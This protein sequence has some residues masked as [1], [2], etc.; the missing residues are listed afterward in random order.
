[1][2]TGNIFTPTIETQAVAP[3]VPSP[4]EDTTTAQAIQAFTPMIA[5]G[6]KFGIAKHDMNKLQGQ[7]EGIN[8]ELS[9]LDKQFSSIDQAAKTGGNKAALQ[10]R[11]RAALKTAIAQNPSISSSAEQMFNNY[12]ATT[13]SSGKGTSGAFTLSPQEKAAQ[14]VKAKV[15]TYQMTFGWDESKALE[16]VQAE[17][18][19]KIAKAKADELANQSNVAQYHVAPIVD[20]MVNGRAVDANSY[21]LNHLKTQGAFSPN[22]KLVYSRKLDAEGAQLKQKFLRSVTNKDGSYSVSPDYVQNQLKKIDDQTTSLKSI[23]SDSSSVKLLE[24]SNRVA[25]AKMNLTMMQKFPKMMTLHKVLGD[26]ATNSFIQAL[27]SGNTRLVSYIE[28]QNPELREILGGQFNFTEDLTVDGSVKM[29]DKDNDAPMTGMEKTA[30]GSFMNSNAQYAMKILEHAGADK[31]T[32]LGKAHPDS[33]ASTHTPNT[34]AVREGNPKMANSV[35][36]MQY[37]VIQHLDESFRDKYGRWPSGLKITVQKSEPEKLGPGYYLM[38]PRAVQQKRILVSA[39]DGT[40]LEQEDVN[41]VAELYRSIEANPDT[42]PEGLKGK[43][44]SPAQIATI[45][46]NAGMDTKNL[47]KF[48]PL[49]QKLSA[50]NM[51]DNNYTEYPPRAPTPYGD[52]TPR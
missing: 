15:A 45:W 43:G 48:E 41:M 28:A 4:V 21:V 6:V 23:V 3:R 7:F 35:S 8:D 51:N 30:T 44:L 16:A 38:W 36:A 14:Q 26:A 20:S 18:G 50:D 37:G 42:I 52:V 10:V 27:S 32:A 46:I 49:I 24:E 2:A 34:K 39:A 31:L 47:S 40:S 12:F 5:E 11:A 22:D 29:L 13:P 9:G 25:N 33:L 1:V 19:A 17:E